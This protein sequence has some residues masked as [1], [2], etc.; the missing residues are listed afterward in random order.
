MI[1]E[2]IIKE[3]TQYATNKCKECSSCNESC[4]LNKIKLFLNF[5]N[6]DNATQTIVDE[7]QLSIFDVLQEE[8]EVPEKLE[9]ITVEKS[10]LI[11]N[12][13]ATVDHKSKLPLLI[14]QYN[15]VV[16]GNCIK[17]SYGEEVKCIRIKTDPYEFNTFTSLERYLVEENNLGRFND[18]EVEIG[19]YLREYFS[20]VEVM[21]LFEIRE[22]RCITESLFIKP[23]AY[24]FDKGKKKDKDNEDEDFNL[25][26]FEAI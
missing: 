7:N 18:I 25:F 11:F 13:T 14:N 5:N 12:D 21:S 24:N 17:D 6:S 16:L 20:N 19:K 1:D 2:E 8:F 15:E 4:I 10:K 22:T 9:I 23:P 3:L 26:N